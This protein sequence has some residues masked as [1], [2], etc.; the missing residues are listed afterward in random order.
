MTYTVNEPERAQELKAAGL[1]GL[2][3]D[4]VDLFG[5]QATHSGDQASALSS[6]S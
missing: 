2:I 5:P 6:L 3:T 4:K 1:D